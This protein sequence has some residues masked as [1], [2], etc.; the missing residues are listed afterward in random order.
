[1]N[2]VGEAIE[3]CAGQAFGGEHAGT[4]IEGQSNSPLFITNPASRQKPP[5]ATHQAQSR[6]LRWPTTMLA[7]VLAFPYAAPPRR[8]PTRRDALE[9]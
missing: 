3:Q 9:C 8:A 1:V 7:A 6:G 2:V 4:F 5:R